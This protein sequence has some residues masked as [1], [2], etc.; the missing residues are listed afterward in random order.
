[1]TP[2]AVAIVYYKIRDHL[3]KCLE[4]V[5]PQRPAEIVVVDNDS[6]DGSVEMMREL[7]PY[8]WFMPCC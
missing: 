7:F 3:R 8:A 4:T 1:M 6:A 5:L 2:P